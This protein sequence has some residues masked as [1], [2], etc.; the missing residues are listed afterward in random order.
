M[1]VSA[2]SDLSAALSSGADAD[3][4]QEA[5]S[6]GLRLGFLLHESIALNDRSAFEE[7]YRVFSSVAPRNLRAANDQE[8]RVAADLAEA[9]LTVGRYDEAYA[10]AMRVLDELGNRSNPIFQNT[11]MNLKFVAFAALLLK[12]DEEG[13]KRMSAE[14]FAEYDS[15]PAGFQNDWEYSGTLHYLDSPGIPSPS[16]RTLRAAIERIMAPKSGLP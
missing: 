2:A 12:K 14:L 11:S 3:S 1:Y 9:T 10:Q 7:S 13:A 8:I 16:R 5:A 6:Y 4:L 15:K